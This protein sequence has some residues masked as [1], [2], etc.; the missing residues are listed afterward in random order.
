MVYPPHC[1]HA[2]QGLDVVC[3]AQ[4]K[5]IWNEVIADYEWQTSQQV[6]KENFTH[7]FDTAFLQ[8]FDAKT[9]K[10]AFMAT[11]VWPFNQEA[12]KTEQ[13]QPS[14]HTSM[15]STYP[16]TMTSPV[17]RVIT[18]FDGV[19]LG[20]SVGSDQQTPETPTRHGQ[21]LMESLSQSA[22]GSFLVL[23]ARFNGTETIGPLVFE[24][25]PYLP[26]PS[27]ELIYS[28]Q[29]NLDTANNTQ[30]RQQVTE[31]IQ[32]LSLAQTH[33][34][35]LREVNRCA[36]AQMAIQKLYGKGMQLGLQEKIK[37]R[38]QD[39]LSL[40]KKGHGGVYTHPDVLAE[41]EEQERQKEERRRAREDRK[42][43]METK[44]QMVEARE[45]AWA[46]A[47]AKWRGERDLWAA[48]DVRLKEA[49]VPSNERPPKPPKMILKAIFIEKWETEHSLDSGE[50]NGDDGSDSEDGGSEQSNDE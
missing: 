11:G 41:I 36:N 31:L 10:A 7:L 40:F 33:I 29:E 21:Q 46:E 12:V 30:L 44:K 37:Q 1:T 13:M 19:P 50:A 6:I 39:T 3:F 15:A 17:R 48:E 25:A 27:W 42:Q 28:A 20:D 49:G 8:A 4:M 35:Q 47:K 23:H 45:K 16:T 26:E 32:T 43:R 34:I 14:E 18:V 2:L 24:G 5:K 22:S 9:I 38:T